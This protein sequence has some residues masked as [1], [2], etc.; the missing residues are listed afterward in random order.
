[1][2]PTILLSALSLFAGSAVFASSPLARSLQEI[3][4]SSF[5]PEQE[6]GMPSGAG[7]NG[8]ESDKRSSDYA[9][10]EFQALRARAAN[11][12]VEALLKLGKMYVDGTTIE[13]NVQEAY[14]LFDAAAK[15]GSDRGRFGAL[16]IRFQGLHE[17]SNE[18]A[19]SRSYDLDSCPK[20]GDYIERFSN[21]D[22][23]YDR[24]LEWPYLFE[25][26]V[27]KDERTR[28]Q[29]TSPIDYPSTFQRKKESTEKPIASCI[30]SPASSSQMASID[31]ERYAQDQIDQYGQHDYPFNY[32]CEPEYCGNLRRFERYQADKVSPPYQAAPIC[33]NNYT[34]EFF[35]ISK[36]NFVKDDPNGNV[37]GE[38]SIKDGFIPQ[39]KSGNRF[40]LNDRYWSML[41]ALSDWQSYGRKFISSGSNG[42]SGGTVTFGAVPFRQS[43][44]DYLMVYRIERRGLH[45][46]FKKA[47]S[48]NF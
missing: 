29:R 16:I 19:G 25:Y 28:Q 15:K 42:V 7:L 18:R 47:P 39:D 27:I 45:C 1:V 31:P 4:A 10:V 32:D 8:N 38:Y 48:L 9:V 43:A 41:E 46:T 36:G 6:T 14:R 33:K 35:D 17:K 21:F 11:G 5:A 13:K 40:L 24:E 12:E 3:G 20:D 37:V 2:R 30:L 22:T 34:N 44:T 26:F 23:K